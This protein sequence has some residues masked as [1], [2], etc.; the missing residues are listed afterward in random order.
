MT[1]N[2]HRVLIVASHPVQY[3]VPIFRLMSKHPKLDINV[4]YC[5]MHGV[6]S[7]FDS[8]FGVEF[9]WDVPL[10]DGYPW[11]EVKNNSL[12]PQLGKF[13][14]L[15]NIDIWKMVTKE[16]FDAVIVYT[17]YTYASFWIALLAAKLKRKVF[18]FSTDSSAL[19]PRNKLQLKTWLKKI[20]LPFI[21]NL[22]DTV[23][24]SSTLGKQMVASLGI[25]G[26]RI[27]LTPS[28]VDNAWWTS[29]SN[30]VDVKVVR[31]KWNIPETATV[32]LFC[33]K[34]QPW[35]RPQDVLK[36][37]IQANVQNSYLVFVGDGS[38]KVEM[39]AEA[40]SLKVQDQ[41][42]FLGFV[43]QSQLPLIYCSADLFILPSEYEPFGVVV[44]EAMLCGLPVIVSDKVGAGYDLVKHDETGF[45]Y[46]CGDIDKLTTIL[47]KILPNRK[48]LDSMGLAA[49]ER[50]RS[51]SPEENIEA[52]VKALNTI[53][54]L[55]E[56]SSLG[57]SLSNNLIS[58]IPPSKRNSDR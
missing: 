34:L 7:S 10:L 24:V 3:A 9:S 21:F 28:S 58:Q 12:K 2:K 51:W 40:N 31:E 36:A 30:Q 54:S 46:P 38:L 52:I 32:L 43:N 25:S 41:V 17:G 5:S 44:N 4:A 57:N 6:A 42:K 20:L 29:Q 50:M 27:T 1:A 35:K 37:F 33:A 16:N 14:G 56:H 13:F 45:V 22:A 26:K 15:F 39:E 48:K 55:R 53:N 18:I 11:V 47:N 49:R 19:E 8:G 23:I